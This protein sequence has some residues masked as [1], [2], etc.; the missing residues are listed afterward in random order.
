MQ[1]AVSIENKIT[2]EVE[3]SDSFESYVPCGIPNEGYQKVKALVYI[4]HLG[5]DRSI[6]VKNRIVNE[7]SNLYIEN[8][9]KYQIGNH[10]DSLWVKEEK[11]VGGTVKKLAIILDMKK[12]KVRYKHYFKIY[13]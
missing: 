9:G 4:K 7:V 3:S 6:I 10:V 1:M 2:Y 5:D 13:I 12:G 11:E 8:E